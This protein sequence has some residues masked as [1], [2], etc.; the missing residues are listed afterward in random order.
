MIRPLH[1]PQKVPNALQKSG[2]MSRDLNGGIPSLWDKVLE[3]QKDGRE[4]VGGMAARIGSPNFLALVTI[5]TEGVSA[6]KKN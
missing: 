5:F 1:S 2:Q 3:A 6:V 4:G